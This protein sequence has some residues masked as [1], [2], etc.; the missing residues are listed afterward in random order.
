MQ[1][2]LKYIGSNIYLLLRF[3]VIWIHGLN[4]LQHRLKNRYLQTTY[5]RVHKGQGHSYDLWKFFFSSEGI[6]FEGKFM[7]NFWVAHL[8]EPFY[9]LGEQF[10]SPPTFYNNEP[11]KTFFYIKIKNVTSV[12]PHTC[13][14][15][16]R[17]PRVSKMDL[18]K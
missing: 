11:C 15:Y 3:N 16:S 7:T 10:K 6:S 12:L 9:F 14:Y 2:T 5:K 8:N 13:F 1:Y 17:F 4:S 18:C